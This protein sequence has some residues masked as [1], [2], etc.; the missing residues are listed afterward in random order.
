MEIIEIFTAAFF[1]VLKIALLKNKRKSQKRR[2]P[3]KNC[4]IK[5]EKKKE[6]EKRKKLKTQITTNIFFYLYVFIKKEIYFVQ[7]FHVAGYLKGSNK[8][9]TPI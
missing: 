2:K 1:R 8:T 4:L 9:P 6:N 3:N 5:Q 7:F